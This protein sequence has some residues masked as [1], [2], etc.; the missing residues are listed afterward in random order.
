MPAETDYFKL[1][2]APSGIVVATH[3]RHARGFIAQ[4]VGLLGRRDLRSGE[5]LWLEGSG[6]VHTLGMRFTLDILFLDK[7]LE[8]VGWDSQVSPNRLMIGYKGA[9]SAIEMAAGALDRV[10]ALAAR[11]LWL[12]QPSRGV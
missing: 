6:Y 2:H 5:G 1:I 7:N 8:A 12:L 10:P 9:K 4:G 11:D 3:V